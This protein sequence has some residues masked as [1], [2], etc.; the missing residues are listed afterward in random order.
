MP[1]PPT[2]D[3]E[4]IKHANTA[5]HDLAASA[6]DV[7]WGIDWG[8]T[9][10]AQVSGK[11]AKALG[12]TPRRFPEALEIGAGT[13]YFSLNLLQAGIVGRLT[14]TDISPG[15]LAE[16]A[17][18][19]EQLGVEI[20][21]VVCEAEQLPFEANRFDLVFG[22]AV[23]HHIPD[24]ERAFAELVRVV[25]PGG[26]VAFCGEPSRHGDRLA[27]APKAI[28]RALAPAWR[29]VVRAERR[30][31]DLEHDDGEGGLEQEV[32]VHAFAPEELRE[33]MRGAGLTHT[34][35]RGEELVANMVGWT[36][37]TIES[38]AEPDTV[39]IAWRQLAFRSYLALQKLDS[40]LLEPGLPA[41]LFY[42]L[43]CSG[44]KS[45]EHRSGA[46][47]HA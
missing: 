47:G 8:S 33:L 29:T 44:R 18:T 34:R 21:T 36:V 19:A 10:Q 26:T 2:L 15:M 39:P 42:N 11:L 43:V 27:A 16:L 20:E 35:V 37:R 32:D 22:H 45:H 3:A 41:E 46:A 1:A 28:G 7:K 14:A 5:Y 13:G 4:R 38:T 40:R 25:R 9:G 12:D 31:A 6:Y 17:G 30:A 23:L 24:L